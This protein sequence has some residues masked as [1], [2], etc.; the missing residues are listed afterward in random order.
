MF[1]NNPLIAYFFYYLNQFLNERR[2]DKKEKKRVIA[3]LN[4]TVYGLRRMQE[5]DTYPSSEV[6][7]MNIL[8]SYCFEVSWLT[9]LRTSNERDEMRETQ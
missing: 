1:L 2:D 8:V 5:H 4:L 6:T 9:S 7:Y 3:E